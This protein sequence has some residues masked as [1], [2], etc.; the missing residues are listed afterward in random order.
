[1]IYRFG[2]P[3]EK[4]LLIVTDASQAVYIAG[5]MSVT[6]ERDLGYL[7]FARL[8][9]LNEK[10]VEFYPVKYSLQPDPFDPLDP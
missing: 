6:A 5:R 8:R 7:P 4:P 10:E 2:L 3:S 1:M 9:L